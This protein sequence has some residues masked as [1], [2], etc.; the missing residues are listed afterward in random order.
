MVRIYILYMYNL[1][2]SPP[3]ADH[4][5]ALVDKYCTSAKEE[6]DPQGQ[7]GQASGDFASAGRDLK[8]NVIPW[9]RRYDDVRFLESVSYLDEGEQKVRVEMRKG[10]R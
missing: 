5:C 10:D 7:R 3:T 6:G 2:E 1:S 4:I 8:L 9:K